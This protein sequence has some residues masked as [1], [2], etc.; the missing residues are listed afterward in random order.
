M[1][2]SNQQSWSRATETEAMAQ[3]QAALARAREKHPGFP[4]DPIHA[5]AIM[6]EEAG[7]TLKAAIDYSYHGGAALAIAEEAAQTAAVAI[8]ILVSL[9]WDHPTRAVSTIEKNE[10]DD[11]P[12]GMELQDDRDFELYLEKINE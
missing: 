7:E 5:A 2:A 12:G 3:I 11:R 4:I 8:R 6:G 10:D 9:A 1:K